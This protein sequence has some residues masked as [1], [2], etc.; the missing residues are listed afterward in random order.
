[1]KIKFKTLGDLRLVC[2]SLKEESDDLQIEFTDSDFNIY[3]IKANLELEDIESDE[4]EF[5]F[6]VL[7]PQEPIGKKLVFYVDEQ[8]E[9]EELELEGWEE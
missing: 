2:D 9:L 7:V 8:E 5:E 3:D 4:E 1:M 6:G